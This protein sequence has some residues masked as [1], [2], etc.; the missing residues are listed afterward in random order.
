MLISLLRDSCKNSN[1]EAKM[2]TKAKKEET[3]SLLKEKFEKA[4]AVYTTDQTGLSVSEVRELRGKLRDVNSEYKIA[5][6]TLMSIA[7]K[8]SDYET[9]TDG[10]VG[11]TALLFCYEDQTAPTGLVSKFAKEHDN[12]I[13]FKGGL[14]DGE[15]LDSEKV[16]Q[17]ASL[18]SKEVLLSQIA[19]LLVGSLSGMAYILQELGNNDD[20]DK[21]LKEFVVESEGS[22]D[23]KSGDDQGDSKEE[24]KAESED[25]P[26][27]VEAEA[28]PEPAAEDKPKEEDKKD[29]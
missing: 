8:G 12:K 5:K 1:F 15:L 16:L 20:K 13:K 10:L 17:I 18:P 24:T 7:A 2:V 14:L 11:P 23:D 26:A 19:G 25:K 9:L 29:E 21:L 4:A 3:I 22:A 28:K 6:N 27:T